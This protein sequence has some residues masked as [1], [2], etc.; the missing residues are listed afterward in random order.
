MLRSRLV[1]CRSVRGEAL[2][3]PDGDREE[4]HERD[5]HDLGQQPEAEPDDQQRGDRDDRQRLRGDQQ[6]GERA[7]Q[8]RREVHRDRERPAQRQRHGEP[9]RGDLQRRHGVGPDLLAERPAL[10]EHPQ[11]RGQHLRPHAGRGDVPLPGDQPDG[12]EHERRQAARAP[13]RRRRAAPSAARP[14]RCPRRTAQARCGVAHRAPRPA[15]VIA[16]GRARLGHGGQ[17]VVG[18]PRRE[19]RPRRQRLAVRAGQRAGVEHEPGVAR[20]LLQRLRPDRARLVAQVALAEHLAGCGSTSSGSVNAPGLASFSSCAR[21]R[22]VVGGELVA[23]LRGLHERPRPARDGRPARASCRSAARCRRPGSRSR[24]R[25][26]SCSGCPRSSAS[27]PSQ[28]TNGSVKSTCP[29]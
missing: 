24:C 25:R 6:R 15:A 13:A 2:D 12:D 22:R 26:R 20:P 5:H 14:T 9:D 11:R 10:L 28:A 21:P 27:M 17:V 19:V 1:A 8:P 18:E 16:A 3:Q 4:R 7:A 23:A 29:A